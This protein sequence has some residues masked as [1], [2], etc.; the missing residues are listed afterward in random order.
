[1][2]KRRTPSLFYWYFPLKNKYH[3]LGLLRKEKTWAKIHHMINLKLKKTLKLN[4]GK[5][6][7]GLFFIF[8]DIM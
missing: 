3:L 1:M 8:I 6:L 2:V 7:A 4:P 5:V